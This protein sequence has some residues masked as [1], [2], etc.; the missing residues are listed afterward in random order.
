[1]P[2]LRTHT[3]M[4]KLALA[5]FA[6]LLPIALANTLVIALGVALFKAIF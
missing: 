2:D 1:M 5:L 3:P 6:A 4:K